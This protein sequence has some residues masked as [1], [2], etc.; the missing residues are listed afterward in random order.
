MEGL[1]P[2]GSV[3]KIVTV[4]EPYRAFP[5]HCW[6]AANKQIAGQKAWIWRR[7]HKSIEIPSAAKEM[8]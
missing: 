4:E 5:S 7:L 2:F 8:W 1:T 3:T 6:E